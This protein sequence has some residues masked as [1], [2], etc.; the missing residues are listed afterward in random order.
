[1]W[2]KFIDDARAAVGMNRQVGPVCGTAR[3]S[4]AIDAAG[5]IYACQRYAAFSNPD[6]NIGNIWDGLN[7]ARLKE[8]Q[9]LL[10]E[11]MF[12]DPA[13]GF[14]CDDCVAR[15]TCRGGCNAMN[16]QTC[17][18]R[19]MI[20]TN[21]CIFHKMWAEIALKALARTGELFQIKCGHN[22]IQKVGKG[23]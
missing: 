10:R 12:P 6:L 18:D 7:E 14:T 21:H 8:T 15:W 1:M 3:N 17:G 19:K 16:F 22:K 20:M 4:L 5:L 13:S 11:N 9:D 2:M 23:E